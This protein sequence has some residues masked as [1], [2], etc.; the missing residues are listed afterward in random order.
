MSIYV[1]KSLHSDFKN[2]KNGCLSNFD[3]DRVEGAHND[4][5][6][7]Q[8]PIIQHTFSKFVFGG[9]NIVVTLTPNAK[10]TLTENV[11]CNL[12]GED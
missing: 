2:E 1:V 12:F 9:T 5:K 4:I 3:P 10:L 11:N 8:C 6:I 7:S